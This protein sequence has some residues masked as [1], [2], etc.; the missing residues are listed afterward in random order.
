MRIEQL[1]SSGAWQVSAAVSNGH[2]TWIEFR[3]F[4]GIDE[5]ESLARYYNTIWGLG[6]TVVE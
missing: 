1:K 5:K 2:D 6:W 3:T 4:Y